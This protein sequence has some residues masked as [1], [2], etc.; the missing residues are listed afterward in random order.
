MGYKNELN[1]GLKK[2]RYGS[3]CAD[4]METKIWRLAD[5]R[6]RAVRDL[7][8]DAVGLRLPSIV[9]VEGFDGRKT[10]ESR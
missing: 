8:N 4:G 10:E 5:D 2:R 3:P 9:L 7:T 6:R 1:V